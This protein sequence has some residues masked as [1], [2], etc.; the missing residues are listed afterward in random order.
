MQERHDGPVL[1]R[2]LVDLF[3]GGDPFVVVGNGKKRGDL[4]TDRFFLPRREREVGIEQIA[5]KYL[6]I[7]GGV[8]STVERRLR[9]LVAAV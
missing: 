5:G 8:I 9:Q 2:L 1:H 6:R 3:V 7:A 4:I